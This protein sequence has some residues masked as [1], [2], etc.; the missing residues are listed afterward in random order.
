MIG[1]SAGSRLWARVETVLPYRRRDASAADLAGQESALLAPAR[2]KE[3]YS[4]S[5]AS[6]TDIPEGTRIVMP[7]QNGAM[8]CL[9]APDFGTTLA[10]CLRNSAAVG[11][12]VEKPGGSVAVIACGER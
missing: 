6:L 12:M 9:R 3:G 5:P 10:G 8:L 4:L 11:A 7:S 1:E 2:G